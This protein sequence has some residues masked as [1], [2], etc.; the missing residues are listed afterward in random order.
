MHQVAAPDTSSLPAPPQ[1][2]PSTASAT[3]GNGRE[4]RQ[5][6]APER[7]GDAEHRPSSA[8]TSHPNVVEKFVSCPSSEHTHSS[9]T[10][11]KTGGKIKPPV[12]TV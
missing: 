6:A 5:G 7:A 10:V 9:P 4:P 1:A 12:E 11:W 8:F 2:E 3:G